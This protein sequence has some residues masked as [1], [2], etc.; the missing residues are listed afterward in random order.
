MEAELPVIDLELGAKLLDGDEAIARS[1]IK[2]L[3]AILPES[4]QDLQNAFR[5]KDIKKLADVAHYVHGGACYCGT[6]RLKAAALAL[7]KQA[8]AA[9]SFQD[10]AMPYQHLCQEIQAVID[11]KF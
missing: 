2:E 7:E 10:M 8:K 5:A 6:P 9:Q 4:L 11:I 1:M 3:A